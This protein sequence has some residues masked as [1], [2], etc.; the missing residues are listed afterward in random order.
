MP[1]DLAKQLGAGG[2]TELLSVMW[3]GYDELHKTKLITPDMHENAI[4]QEFSP[5]VDGTIST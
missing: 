4:T 2:I 5:V 3:Q 1:I